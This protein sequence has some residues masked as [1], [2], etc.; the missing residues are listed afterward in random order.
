MEKD[1]RFLS[2][3]ADDCK[4]PETATLYLKELH[5]VTMAQP[6]SLLAPGEALCLPNFSCSY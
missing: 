6:A 4:P 1:M 2:G 3:F 5:K